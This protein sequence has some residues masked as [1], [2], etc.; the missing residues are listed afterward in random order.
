MQKLN[1]PAYAYRLK[2]ADG[3]VWIFDGIRKKYVVLT[4]EEWVRQHLINYLLNHRNYP[5]GLITVETGLTYNS[6]QKRTDMVVFDRQGNTW[7]VVE[8]K[9]ADH[10]ITYDTALQ[11]AVY[12]AALKARY[13]LITNGVNQYCFAIN[14]SEGRVVHLESIPEYPTGE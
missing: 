9:A 8:C 6:L 11:V 13:I 7:M 12:N 3:K 14:F 1:L 4:P 10:P 2:K 5:K